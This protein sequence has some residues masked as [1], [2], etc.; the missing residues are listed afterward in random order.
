MDKKEDTRTVARQIEHPRVEAEQAAEV[1]GGLTSPGW[2][3]GSW[4]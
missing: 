4:S 2:P 3:I 1:K